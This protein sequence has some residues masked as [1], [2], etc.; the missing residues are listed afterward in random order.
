MTLFREAAVVRSQSFLI[1]RTIHH[2]NDIEY[3]KKLIVWSE[4][5]TVRRA[6]LI[7]G[8]EAKGFDVMKDEEFLE[9]L[10][11]A[12]R[13][14]M[15]ARARHLS[16][17]LDEKRREHL[18]ALQ[19]HLRMQELSR[20][21]CDHCGRPLRDTEGA[22]KKYSA[23]YRR[24]EYGRTYRWIYSLHAGCLAELLGE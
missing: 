15:Q 4:P 12:D 24:G 13:N 23:V 20:S 1:E 19:G 5:D 11:L 7:Q 2:C 21:D 16:R 8:F 18:V 3:A 10:V 9:R 17:W 6:K 22:T 14:H